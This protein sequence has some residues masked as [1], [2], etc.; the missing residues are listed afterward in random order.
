[1]CF[2]FVNYQTG[3]GQ[4]QFSDCKFTMQIK[5]ILE[6]KKKNLLLFLLSKI[7]TMTTILVSF[8]M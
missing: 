2:S 6:E 4:G 1:M 5:S 3:K 8:S 7:T